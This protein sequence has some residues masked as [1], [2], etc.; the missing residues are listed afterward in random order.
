MSRKKDTN[1][2]TADSEMKNRLISLHQNYGHLLT[3]NHITVLGRQ[4][5][6][7]PIMEI[8]AVDVLT[9]RIVGLLG[10]DR[11]RLFRRNARVVIIGCNRRHVSARIGF[12][13]CRQLHGLCIFGIADIGGRCSRRL[14]HYRRWSLLMFMGIKTWYPGEGGNK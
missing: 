11:L 5:F 7:A 12:R 6:R 1:V 3:V 9:L 4:C 8:V 2:G 13:Q 10:S 14:L